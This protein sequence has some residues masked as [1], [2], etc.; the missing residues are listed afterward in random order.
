MELVLIAALIVV[1]LVILLAM[2]PQMEKLTELN[3]ATMSR[4]LNASN[5]NGYSPVI[6]T[7]STMERTNAAG[8]TV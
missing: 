2:S 3:W 5:A 8:I 1:V 7:L 6:S 4:G